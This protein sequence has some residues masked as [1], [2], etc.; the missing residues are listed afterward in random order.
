M[1][2][3]F[4]NRLREYCEKEN[5]KGYDPFDGL[6]SKFFR[7][8]PYIRN[9]RLCRLAW[10]QF[11]KRS[12]VNFRPFLGVK[13]AYNPK[14]LGLFLSGYCNLYKTEK[15]E[16]YLEKINYLIDKINACQSKGY[17][18]ACWGY[19]F[20]WQAKAFFQPKG[21]PSV[22]V[23]SYIAGALL[24][25]YAVLQ[26]KKLLET[27]RSTCDFILADLYR[28]YDAQGDFAFSY[29]PVDKTQV[30]NASLLGCRLLCRMYAF[31]KEPLLLE[32]SKKAVAFACKHQQENGAWT[33]SPL[34]FHQWVDNFHT[35]YNLECIYTYQTVSGDNGFANHF[36]RGLNYY[37]ETFFEK[38]GT[39]KYYSHS[40]Y[41]VDMHNTAQ[42]MVTLSKTGRFEENKELINKVLHWSQ[43]NMFDTKKG[44][45]YYV[46]QKSGIVKINYIR[47]TQAW[48]FFAYS[49]YILNILNIK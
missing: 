32:E 43:E 3:K 39:P 47:W 24:D 11:F 44:Y 6:N 1:D 36:E 35:G 48:M 16:A 33:Y 19:N 26:D 10:L 12:P 29:S 8:L 14:G 22:V 37:L 7:A 23:S 30:F 17:S 34:P 15:K 49:H 13:K 45:F 20:D 38:D 40:R 18:G 28:T 41:P 46:K 4:L 31:T 2:N 5:F 25:A 9:N 27:A 21:T 42:L